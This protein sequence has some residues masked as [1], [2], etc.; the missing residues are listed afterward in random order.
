MA[1]CDCEH[2]SHM[3]KDPR[4]APPGSERKASPNGNPNHK[5]GQEFHE[6]A[7]VRI[8][9]TYGPLVVCQDCLSDCQYGSEVVS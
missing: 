6:R 2:I 8:R 7:V 5:Y 1:R 4:F 9:T 3:W